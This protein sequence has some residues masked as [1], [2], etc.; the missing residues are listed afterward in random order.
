MFLISC[1]CGRN[2]IFYSESYYSL[3]FTGEKKLRLGKIN[4]PAQGY[5]IVRSAEQE[6]KHMSIGFISWRPWCKRF[7]PGAP[8]VLSLGTA[9]RELIPGALLRSLRPEEACPS[10]YPRG[11]P[12]TQFRPMVRLLFFFFFKQHIPFLKTEV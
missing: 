7:R 6:L 11:H 1:F 10:P 3:Y 5:I 4:Y 8:A 2:T 9:K 12:S